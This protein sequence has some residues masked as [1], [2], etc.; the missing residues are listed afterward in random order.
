MFCRNCANVLIDTDVTCPHCGFAVGTG[1]KYCAN[2]GEMVK[3][4]A[5]VCDICGA[6]LP[7]APPQQFAQQPYGQPYQQQGP[8]Q[9]PYGQQPPPYGQPGQQPYGQQPPPY[10]QQQYGQQAYGQPPY[11]QQPVYG[12][13]YGVSPKSKTAAAILAFFLGSLGVHNFYL[14][15]NAKG[16]AQL[17]LTLLTCGV[18]GV[19]SEIWSIVEGVMLLTGNIN[20]DGHG[21]PL[22]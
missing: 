19:I 8:P 14:G 5:V 1:T 13:H 18:G 3:P 10:G 12:Q 6:K 21:L 15:Y 22:N 17:V 4:G 7:Q 9:Q 11:S 16:V 20:T 2:C